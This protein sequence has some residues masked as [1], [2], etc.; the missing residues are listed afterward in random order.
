[1]YWLAVAVIVDVL[2]AVVVDKNEVSIKGNF[3]LT[4]CLKSIPTK[5]AA[6]FSVSVLFLCFM[7]FFKTNTK[8]P[9]F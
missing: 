6:M 9:C 3:G 4:G 1:M 5:Y 8:Y 2:V 7:F